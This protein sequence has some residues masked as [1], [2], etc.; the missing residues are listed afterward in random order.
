V[1]IQNEGVLVAG[2][3]LMARMMIKGRG[4]SETERKGGTGSKSPLGRFVVS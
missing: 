1:T 2:R 4:S 3:G